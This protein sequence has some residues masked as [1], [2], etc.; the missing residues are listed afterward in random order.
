V[1]PAARSAPAFAMP[2]QVRELEELS[3]VSKFIAPNER[4][5]TAPARRSRELSGDMR[6]DRKTSGRA[7]PDIDHENQL[8][9]AGRKA[10]D[11]G[12]ATVFFEEFDDGQRLPREGSLFQDGLRA[13]VEIGICRSLNE[14]GV[15]DDRLGR[16]CIGNHRRRKCKRSRS[17][18]R[19]A[20]GGPS[21]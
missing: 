17:R 6:N 13:L 15:L 1:A 19:Q 20:P 3:I 10:T 8:F 21:S 4:P 14:T 7:A 5:G 2:E 16:V 18:K 9:P 12:R 11:R